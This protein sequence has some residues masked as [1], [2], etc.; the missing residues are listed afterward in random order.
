M[1]P[2]IENAHAAADARL[3]VQVIDA[4]Q[5]A[6]LAVKARFDIEARPNNK[7]D[8]NTLIAANDA[9]SFGILRAALT[10][11]R[12]AVQWIED[13]AASGPLPPGEWW[14]VDP[15]EGAINHIHGT[16]DW[17]V[18]ATLVR[19]N[20]PVLTAIYLPMNGDTYS[21]VRGG[22]AWHNAKRLSTSNKTSLNAAMVGTGQAVPNEGSATYQRIGIAVAAMLEAALVVRVSVPTTL[23]M[24]HVAAGHQ[25]VFWQYSKVRTGL[26][27][28]ALLVAEAGG[29]VTDLQGEPW[30]LGK[31]G[32]LASTPALVA[33]AVAV[34]S[35]I[36]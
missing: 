19:D 23:Q 29:S 17:G 16:C 32:M 28:G 3:L 5:A 11:A 7:L 18:T 1:K 15:V 27:A 21:A 34:L 25:D 14:V 35:S 13:E 2:S 30:H 31:S 12:P 36:A 10:V 20:T 24:V 4:V 9:V 22:G 8:I 6:G 26:L 33:P